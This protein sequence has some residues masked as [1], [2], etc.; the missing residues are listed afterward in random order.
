MTQIL[1]EPGIHRS[2]QPA[3]ARQVF[4]IEL[5]H[6]TPN[7][8]FVKRRAPWNAGQVHAEATREGES[9]R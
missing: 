1:N 7:Q 4:P 6:L 5:A 2:L 8:A 9:E 3:V